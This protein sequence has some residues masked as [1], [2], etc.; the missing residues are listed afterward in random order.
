MG[1][2][3][4]LGTY[5]LLTPTLL[6]FTLMLYLSVSYNKHGALSFSPF[7]KQ[8]SVA[9]AALPAPLNI[10]KFAIG[11]KDARVQV[12]QSFFASYNSPLTP[13]A[14][15][16]VATA[17]KYNID[18][19]L[20]PAIAM[21]ESNLCKKIIKNSYNC[22]GYGIYGKNVVTFKNYQ[23]AIETI[24]KTLAKDYKTKRGLVTPEQI[25]M[26]YTAPSSKENWVKG[27]THFM[28]EI[29]H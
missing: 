17:D 11:Q 22:W 14:E 9:Y 3:L 12:V 13:Y 7:Q 5:L 15:H 23:E 16:I 19:R 28:T 6:A 21:Q 29:T 4:L 18:H 2:V 26:R 27:V 25:A 10:I 20:L 8:Q 24:T 1:K